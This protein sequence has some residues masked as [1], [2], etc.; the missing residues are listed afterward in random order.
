MPEQLE[1]ELDQVSLND[2]R[3]DIQTFDR[4]KGRK[5]VTDRIAILST[6]LVRAR[7]HYVEAKKK[8]VRCHSTPQKQAICCKHLGE[9]EQKFGL[10]LFQYTTD[11]SGAMLT[12]ERLSGKIKLWVISESRYAE[13]SQIHREFPLLDSGYGEAQMDLLMKCT[14][15][16][17]QRL[18]FTP[19]RDAFFK[20]KKE[21]YDALKLKEAK[22]KAKLGKAMGN[23]LTEL[24][25]MELLEVAPTHSPSKGQGGDVNIGD[26]VLD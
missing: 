17:W 12:D 11:D 25:L 3:V 22:A 18:T 24:E 21:W 7:T 19:C 14:E 4:Y 15:E 26:D 5:N 1:Q 2:K 23:E 16:Q 8:T 10:V 20:K 13:L 9:P 6:T